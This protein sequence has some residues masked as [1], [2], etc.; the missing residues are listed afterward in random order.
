LSVFK[1]YG[2]QAVMLALGSRRPDTTEQ[3]MAESKQ[4]ATLPLI[5]L[6]VAFLVAC[7]GASTDEVAGDSTT[8]AGDT[9]TPTAP[10]FYAE[11]EEIARA[12]DVLGSY[13][14][15]YQ[16]ADEFSRMPEA[17]GK[18]LAELEASEAWPIF[19][20]LQERWVVCGLELPKDAL[21]VIR[22]GDRL[23]GAHAS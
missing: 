7:S 20:T 6:A 13:D 17:E 10:P 2:R 19:K 23:Y 22:A 18:P 4:R 3:V 16:Q 9:P 5:L 1:T 21:K 11:C 8:D 15:W 14:V 12:I